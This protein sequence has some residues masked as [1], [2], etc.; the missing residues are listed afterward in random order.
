MKR[1]L[2]TLALSYYSY[3]FI[4]I[5][6][7]YLLRIYQFSPIGS[8][9]AISLLVVG[10]GIGVFAPGVIARRLRKEEK[11]PIPFWF[12]SPRLILAFMGVL[13]SLC[14][15][16]GAFTF[17]LPLKEQGSRIGGLV[18]SVLYGAVTSASVSLFWNGYIF[19]R[20]AVA[21]A[22][23]LTRVQALFYMALIGVPLIIW[24]AFSKSTSLFSASLSS[25][26]FLVVGYFGLLLNNI[27]VLRM[28]AYSNSVL[29]PACVN[30][31]L[32]TALSLWFFR[33]AGQRG[34]LVG[35]G[36]WGGVAWIIASY[37]F[38][39]YQARWVSQKS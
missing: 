36:M 26:V 25:A 23:E 38:L 28:Q 39:Y 20:L 37:V 18:L 31:G 10:A 22:R 21:T 4:I 5:G 32:L 24:V 30:G 16:E 14:A 1:A 11:D 8:W 29:Y 27:V 3:L 9:F 2:I 33:E 13:L 19:P 35:A 12:N 15:A 34:P 17:S 7:S 6:A